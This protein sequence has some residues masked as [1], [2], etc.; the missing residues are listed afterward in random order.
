MRL[1]V[2]IDRGVLPLVMAMNAGGR[3]RT[4]ASCQGHPLRSQPPYVM[5]AGGMD[6]AR[7]LEGRLRK[8]W[9]MGDLHY[10]WEVEG[11]FDGF[12]RLVFSLRLFALQSDRDRPRLSSHKIQ[13]DLRSLVGVV[14]GV[15][16]HAG[17]TVAHVP[18][19]ENK[20]AATNG[21]ADQ[22]SENTLA[23]LAE[24]LANGPRTWRV[25]TIGTHL[26][27]LRNLLLAFDT[28]Y[29][30]HGIPY[31]LQANIRSEDLTVLSAWCQSIKTHDPLGMLGNSGAL[32]C[33]GYAG[34]DGWPP[35]CSVSQRWFL[36]RGDHIAMVRAAANVRHLMWIDSSRLLGRWDVSL[37]FDSSLRE[38]LVIWGNPPRDAET[39]DALDMDTARVAKEIE[40]WGSE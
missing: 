23:S 5:F 19:Q 24:L 12:H 33:L 38:I 29:K 20:S 1:P 13:E 16:E 6:D 14:K 4:I 3:F 35:L 28:R 34:A 27:R 15:P 37:R 26:S 10:E 7:D 11:N 22:N 31:S 32:T 18:P 9:A 30:P 40:H 21:E 8:A 17:G 39:S 2:P 25:P 36:F